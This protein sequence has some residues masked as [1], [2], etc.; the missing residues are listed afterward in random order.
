[1]ESKLPLLDRPV[2]PRDKVLR[3]GTQL[4]LE[5]WPTEKM[6]D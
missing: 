6:A 4:Y 5:S 2:N 3:Q 1:M